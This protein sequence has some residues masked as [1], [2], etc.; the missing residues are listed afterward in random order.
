[1][2]KKI[3]FCPRCMNIIH[4]KDEKCSSCGLAVSEMQKMQEQMDKK[5]DNEEVVNIVNEET[6]DNNQIKNDSILETKAD[7][8]ISSFSQEEID[9]YDMENVG[10]LRFE[11]DKEQTDEPKRHKHKPKKKEDL[12]NYSI[13][14]DG[15]YNID[16]KDVTFLEGVE[17]PTYSIKKARGE[18]VTEEKL[19]WWEIYKW[20][21]RMFAKRKI[22]K[23]VNKASYKTPEGISR[24]AMIVWCIFF[25]WLGIHNFY[26][27]NKKRGWTL[28]CFDIIIPLVLYIEPLYEFMGVFV[29]GGLGFV[30]MTM[31]I[32][33][34]IRLIIN[35]YRY[36]ISKEE[37][38]SNLNVET[39]AKI[40]KKYI[41]L[42]KTVFKQKEKE[43]LE[44]LYKK[45]NKAGIKK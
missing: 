9:N 24:S 14:E 3:M 4:K 27:G 8:G 22:M 33:D 38:I 42:D 15:S 40:G 32:G 19:E 29:G 26:G 37:F 11:E 44:K 43:R 6:N 23:E 41:D 35:R 17:K 20:A 16:T 13:D 34:L 39:R 25:G 30:M 45:K 1:M 28:V 21:D 10:K 7:S 31:W 36:K 2:A 18:N 12:P 5:V